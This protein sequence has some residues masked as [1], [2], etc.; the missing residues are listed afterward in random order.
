MGA[1]HSNSWDNWYERDM[2][3]LA[4]HNILCSFLLQEFFRLLSLLFVFSLLLYLLSPSF[5]LCL[6]S[7]SLCY[8][9]LSSLPPPLTLTLLYLP[10]LLS[11]LCPLS[12]VVVNTGDLMMRWTN[13][14][15]RSTVHRYPLIFQYEREQDQIAVQERRQDKQENS[16]QGKCDT[17]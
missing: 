13:D 14:L 7:S 9:S 6:H 11:S 4:M 3:I 17:S 12:S 5:P 15:F 8:L 1:S 10:Y 16:R 2:L